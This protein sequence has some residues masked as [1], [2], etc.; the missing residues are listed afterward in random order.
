MQSKS[1]MQISK[2]R[3]GWSLCYKANTNI[4]KK[5]NTIKFLSGTIAQILISK[6]YV[7]QLYCRNI[8]YQIPG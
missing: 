3:G 4:T 6:Q 5:I 1:I 8:A 2:G 7:L